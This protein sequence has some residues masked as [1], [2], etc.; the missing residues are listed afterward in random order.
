[1]RLEENAQARELGERPADLGG[2]LPLQRLPLGAEVSARLLAHADPAAEHLQPEVY[3]LLAVVPQPVLHG[4]ARQLEALRGEADAAAGSVEIFAGLELLGLLQLVVLPVVLRGVLL[5]VLDREVLRRALAVVAEEERHVH[6]VGH[7]PRAVLVAA[8]APVLERLVEPHHLGE[9][10]LGGDVGLE[11]APRDG[12]HGRESVVGPWRLGGAGERPCRERLARLEREVRVAARR[13][14]ALVGVGDGC[15]GDGPEDAVAERA[16]RIPH[17]RAG[18]DVRGGVRHGR[19]E[20]EHL[21]RVFG[22]GA[23]RDAAAVVGKRP[24]FA[25]LLPARGDVERGEALVV[26]LHGLHELVAVVEDAGDQVARG[27]EAGLGLEDELERDVRGGSVLRRHGNGPFVARAHGLHLGGEP[28]CR[29]NRPGREGDVR[30]RRTGKS[31][32]GNRKERWFRV[33][34]HVLP[35][36]VLFAHYTTF[37]SPPAPLP[38]LSACGQTHACDM[39]IML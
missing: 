35:F 15:L 12:E 32:G 8:A 24:R 39:I 14:G 33:F 16:V 26:A 21:V 3:V 38:P 1:M 10:E 30:P 20:R 2:V 5:D 7:V 36:R 25:V 19:E 23:G 13:E 29:R 34:E 4:E 31:H 27:D 9:R 22:D 17:E 18:A 11:Q 37:T 6:E 28:V